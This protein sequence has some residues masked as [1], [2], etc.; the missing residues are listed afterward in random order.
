MVARLKE[1]KIE[2]PWWVRFRRRMAERII[3]FALW[4]DKESW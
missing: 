1:R 4:V 2:R 3:G